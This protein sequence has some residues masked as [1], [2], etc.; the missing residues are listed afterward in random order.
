MVAVTAKFEPIMYNH[1]V[2]S[3]NK[4]WA[5]LDKMGIKRI[6]FSDAEN[7][8]YIDTAYQVEWD[9]LS[10]KVPDQVAELKK[11]TSSD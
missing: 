10:K 2:Q 1:F 9:N 4:E 6:K 3:V 8:K 7:K 5:E 11:I